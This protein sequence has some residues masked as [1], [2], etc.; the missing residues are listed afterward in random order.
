MKLS[1]VMGHAGLSGYAEVA[2]VIF[3]VVF[4]AVAVRTLRRAARS[5]LLRAARLPL[6]DGAVAGS[7]T[8]GGES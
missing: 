3:A 1:D 4:T 2:L 5:E 7:T 8:D 6:H